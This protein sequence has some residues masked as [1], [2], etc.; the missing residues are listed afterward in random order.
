MGQF[1]RKQLHGEGQASHRLVCIQDGLVAAKLC[2]AQEQSRR[3]PV[4]RRLLSRY[5]ISSLKQRR[6]IV[7]HSNKKALQGEGVKTL[8]EAAAGPRCRGGLADGDPLG[9][10]AG[11]VRLSGLNVATC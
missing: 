2:K 11:L 7:R 6:E 3:K 8:K 9:D 10:G 4:A 1:C 5:V